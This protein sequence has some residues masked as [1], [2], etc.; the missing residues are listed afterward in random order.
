MSSDPRQTS[1]SLRYSLA[2][3]PRTQIHDWFEDLSAKSRGLCT[4]WDSTGAITFIA[5]D[6]VWR[7]IPGHTTGPANQLVYRDRPD[8]APPAD[9]DPQATAV[10]L[11]KW[12]LE[13]QMHF[14]Y[15]TAQSTLATAIPDSIGLAN[16]AARAQSGSPSHA[17]TF[18]YATA[19]G[20]RNVSETRG[21]H[22]P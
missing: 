6:P 14:A 8:F 13:M 18:S 19:N 11:A 17:V 7:A 12:R 2:D 20:N 5:T 21:S 16:Q 22:R 4:Q 9:L 1:V 10:D 3:S 15:T